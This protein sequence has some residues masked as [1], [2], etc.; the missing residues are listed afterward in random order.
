ML[1]FVSKKTRNEKYRSA[2]GSIHPICYIFDVFNKMM[3]DFSFKFFNYFETFEMKIKAFSLS[4]L[5][6]YSSLQALF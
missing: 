4:L 2:L 6:V 5:I 3:D 1:L